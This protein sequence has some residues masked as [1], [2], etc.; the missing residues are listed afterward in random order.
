M[1]YYWYNDII[2]GSRYLGFDQ[3]SNTKSLCLFLYYFVLDFYFLEL[4]LKK[5]SH[6]F[7]ISLSCQLCVCRHPLFLFCIFASSFPWSWLVGML[8]GIS[9]MRWSLIQTI[10]APSCWATMTWDDK[11]RDDKKTPKN[12]FLTYLHS[13]WCNFL[14]SLFTEQI[15][16]IKT[17]HIVFY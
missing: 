8:T 15:H 3:S 7:I 2:T 4:H 11:S 16:W 5:A 9:M 13:L 6:I 12:I 17:S 1:F 14:K 10:V